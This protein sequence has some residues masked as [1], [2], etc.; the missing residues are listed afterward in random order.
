MTGM[1]DIAVIGA[2]V[3][4]LTCAL[5]LAQDGHAVALIDPA[6]PG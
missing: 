4:G 1:T 6:D 5:R 3:I 2:G